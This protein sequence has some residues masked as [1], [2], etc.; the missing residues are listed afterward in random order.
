MK[1]NQEKTLAFNPITENLARMGYVARGL[2]YLVIGVLAIMLVFGVSGGLKDQ[3]GA[4]AFIGQQL[5][6]K[7]L[8]GFFLIGLA[9]YVLWGLNRAILN[10]LHKEN[11]FKGILARV[12]FFV[13]AAAYAILI[14]PTYN[15]IFS[16]PNA[17]QNGAQSIQLRNLIGTIFLMPLGEWIV[18]IIGLIFLGVG[19]FQVYKGLKHNFDE[20]IKS[21]NLS[22]TKLKIVK[23]IGRF[24]TVARAIVFFLIGLF[25]LFAAYKANSAEVKGIDGVLLIILQQSCGPWLLGVVALGLV[26]FGFYSLLSGFWFKMR[27]P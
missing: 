12:G 14:I 17:A 21:Y 2:L 9:G 16:S 4:I 25:L 3:Q 1:S 7:I 19:I 11:N 18:G 22:S 20:Q 27:K 15:Y 10:P 5:F 24:G 23:I 8:L 6:G 26:A 13:S